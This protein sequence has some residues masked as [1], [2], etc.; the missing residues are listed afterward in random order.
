MILSTD[1]EAWPTQTHET[2]ATS[3][4]E[5]PYSLSLLGAPSLSAPFE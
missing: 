5:P 1:T 3:S 4:S 2:L